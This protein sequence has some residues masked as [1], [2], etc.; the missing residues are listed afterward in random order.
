MHPDSMKVRLAVFAV[1]V[2]ASVFAILAK[3]PNLDEFWTVVFADPRLDPATAWL[4][5]SA[6]TTHPPGYYA[7]VRLWL[8]GPPVTVTSARFLNLLPWTALGF[9]W[10]FSPAN[11][12]KQR[13]FCVAFFMCISVTYHGLER[14]AEARA[15][16][17][18]FALVCLLATE[19]K[20][21]E[22]GRA[23]RGRI[24]RIIAASVCIA[25]LDYPIFCAAAALLSV[26]AAALLL[27]S[28]RRDAGWIGVAVGAGCIVLLAG[29][30]NAMGHEQ[31]T[32]PYYVSTLAYARTALIVVAAGLA[33]NVA[34]S[35]LSAQSIVGHFG[36]G[37]L[38]EKRYREYD[39]RYVIAVATAA[40]VIEF[41]V[42]NLVLH[43]I[44]SRHLIPFVAL[45]CASRAAWLP[46]RAWSRRV[47]WAIFLTFA[48]SAVLVSYRLAGMDNLHRFADLL[49]AEQRKCAGFKIIPIDMYEL[50]GTPNS[51]LWQTRARASRFG[52]SEIARDFGFSLASPLDRTMDPRCGG[53]AW[54]VPA[55]PDQ[56][57]TAASVLDAVHVPLDAKQRAGARMLHENTVLV[58]RVPASAPPDRQP[59][60]R[61]P[62]VMNDPTRSTK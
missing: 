15:Y 38:R 42:L 48:A 36:R 19:L 32:V 46:D 47:A 33:G 35:V 16:F 62:A 41:L 34:I 12:G 60:A 39:Y 7:L 53:A 40:E 9:Y 13:A 23:S 3:G 14:L 11:S 6:D 51:L 45:V 29:M 4:W 25:A 30:V 2:S 37:Y 21:L 61:P 1:A 24:A 52:Q 5:W 10:L 57:A 31:V 56:Q 27:A 54:F 20:G 49:A 22:S 59:A 50:G 28:R 58:V 18:A 17:L 55:Y 8:N 26:A 44:I 43:A